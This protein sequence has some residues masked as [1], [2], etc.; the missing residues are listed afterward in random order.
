MNTDIK[1]EGMQ[2]L[3]TL[4]FTAVMAIGFAIGGWVAGKVLKG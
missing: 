3:N 4:I 2:L 1:D